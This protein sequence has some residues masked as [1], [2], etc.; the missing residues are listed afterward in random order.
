MPIGIDDLDYSEFEEQPVV[1][2]PQEEETQP[3]EEPAGS[4]TEEPEDALYTFLKSKGIEDPKKIKFENEYGDI[5]EVDWETLTNEEKL[6]I[7]STSDEDPDRALDDSEIEYIN[8]IRLSGLTPAEYEA[9]V[10]KNAVEAS[11]TPETPSYEIDNISDDQLYL[12]DLQQK[13][14]DLT[15]AEMEQALEQEKQNPDLYAKK[16][17]G[18]RNEYKALEDQI[19]NNELAEQQKLQEEQFAQFQNTILDEIQSLNKIGNLDIEMEA[20][21][22]NDVANFIL[23]NDSAGINFLAKAL[24]D[25]KQLVKA[26]WFLTKGE[27]ALSSISDYFTQQIKEVSKAQYKKGLEEGK[28]GKTSTQQKPRVVQKPIQTNQNNKQKVYRTIDDLD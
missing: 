22:M 27:E 20:D 25:P 11:K 21:D 4:S 6:N 26:A 3:V 18:L 14:G 19:K 1:E 10:T 24:N 8:K 2:E 17:A 23:S 7:L 16:I 12:L 9:M 15:E 13:I 28:A 5:E